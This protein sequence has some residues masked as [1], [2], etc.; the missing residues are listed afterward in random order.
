MPPENIWVIGLCKLSHEVN[1][2]HAPVVF[3]VKYQK[4]RGW[5][6]WCGD[7]QEDTDWVVTAW[8]PLPPDKPLINLQLM[9]KISE[10]MN[11][12]GE[13]PPEFQKQLIDN[14]WSLL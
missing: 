13:F 4:E 10:A 11:G 7:L 6:D 12:E 14:F 5:S 8:M 1:K 2:G 9:N 3:Q